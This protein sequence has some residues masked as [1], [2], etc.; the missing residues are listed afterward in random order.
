LRNKQYGDAKREIEHFL[1]KSKKEKFTTIIKE[2][3]PLVNDL[4]GA[5]EH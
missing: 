5:S 2:I 4:L 1:K 3:F